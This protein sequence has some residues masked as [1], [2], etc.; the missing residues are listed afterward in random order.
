MKVE[1][2]IRAN[3]TPHLSQEG[4]HLQSQLFVH[5]EVALLDLVVHLVDQQEAL[6]LRFSFHLSPEAQPAQTG[7]VKLGLLGSL[8]LVKKNNKKNPTCFYMLAAQSESP[9]FS[10]DAA[11]S[12][13]APT[14][15]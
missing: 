8:K 10:Q 15:K 7:T 6:S 1:F 11:L 13:P 3:P 2:E 9:H 12:G 5:G 4:S 14:W